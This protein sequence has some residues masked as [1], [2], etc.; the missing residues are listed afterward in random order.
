MKSQT[1][2]AKQM[3]TNTAKKNVFCP[4]PNLQHTCFICD[5]F[6]ICFCDQ[7][8]LI[9]DCMQPHVKQKLIKQFNTLEND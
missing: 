2:A 5:R 3:R 4:T 9:D 7:I 8:E 1:T 6:D